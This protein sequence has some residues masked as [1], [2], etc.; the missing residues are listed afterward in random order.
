MVLCRYMTSLLRIAYETAH[1]ARKSPRQSKHRP[2]LPMLSFGGACTQTA[3]RS[4]DYPA[5]ET[6][7]EPHAFKAVGV[8]DDAHHQ[9]GVNLERGGAD[10]SRSLAQRRGSVDHDSALDCGLPTRPREHAR[11]QHQR[12]E[13]E[14]DRCAEAYEA[15]TT[16]GASRREQQ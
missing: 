2:R 7:V 1:L 15:R 12:R 14:R 6:V 3:N 13:R 16:R 8:V 10:R 4:L 9:T 11:A 5:F